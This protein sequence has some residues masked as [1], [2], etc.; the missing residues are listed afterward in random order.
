MIKL[1]AGIG[2]L[3]FSVL[4]GLLLS[5]FSF[6]ALASSD[7]DELKGCERKFC[8][9]EKQI[10]IA[11]ENNNAR[12]EKGLRKALEEA[13]ES[14]TEQALGDDLINDIKKSEEDVL[15]YQADLKDAEREGDAEK[16]LKYRKKIEEEKRE[17]KSLE[18]TLSR[19]H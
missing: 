13:R 1:P 18:E 12:R 8:A 19:L 15:E 17:I 9:I 14:C 3:P 2:A 11:Q 4:V 10:G 5:V 16:V 6:P 7:C